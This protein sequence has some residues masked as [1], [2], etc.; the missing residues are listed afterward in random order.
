MDNDFFFFFE[1]TLVMEVLIESDTF[2]SELNF[3]Q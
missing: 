3:T 1:L 2:T